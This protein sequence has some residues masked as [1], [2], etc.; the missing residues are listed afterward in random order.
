MNYPLPHFPILIEGHLDFLGQF[1]LRGTIFRENPEAL[2][3]IARR[4][5]VA[6]GE[7]GLEGF[8]GRVEEFGQ[9][10]ILRGMDVGL[11]FG[12]LDPPEHGDAVELEALGQGIDA[13]TRQ[14]A[15]EDHFPLLLA[16]IRVIEAG[17]ASQRTT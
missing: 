2:E 10:A 7:E 14:P 11:P 15:R 12:L 6:L 13:L 1:R 5:V 4:V 9:H 3:N 16:E 17:F 8:N